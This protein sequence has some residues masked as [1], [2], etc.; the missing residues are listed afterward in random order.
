LNDDLAAELGEGKRGK[1]GE[2][3]VS[4]KTIS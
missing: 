2:C 1:N 3:Q 4:E